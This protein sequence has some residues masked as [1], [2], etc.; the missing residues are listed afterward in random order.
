[1]NKIEFI[2]ELRR[3]SFNLEDISEDNNHRLCFGL[4][5]AKEIADKVWELQD[6]LNFIPIKEESL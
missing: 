4:K 6:K 1:M 3:I 2:I 5:L